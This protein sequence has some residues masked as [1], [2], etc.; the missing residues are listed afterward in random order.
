M[1][2]LYNLKAI[3]YPN[4]HWRI[5]ELLNGSH[6]DLLFIDSLDKLED[7]LDRFYTYEVGEEAICLTKLQSILSVPEY[8]LL[9]KGTSVREAMRLH[10][11]C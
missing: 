4:Q 7:F 3:S 10:R 2:I 1:T 5:G 9:P 8:F 11:M 6:P